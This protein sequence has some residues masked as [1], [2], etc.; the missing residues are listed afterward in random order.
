[1]SSCP[2]GEM[3]IK[4][5]VSRLAEQ[6]FFM[7]EQYTSVEAVSRVKNFID[8]LGLEGYRLTTD[9]FVLFKNAAGGFLVE[10]SNG[11]SNIYLGMDA[12]ALGVFLNALGTPL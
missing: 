12:T 7:S 4:E 2:V 9:S 8:T 6:D 10:L 1:M 5:A 3:S 11:C